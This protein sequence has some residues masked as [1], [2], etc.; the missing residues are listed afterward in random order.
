M[1]KISFYHIISW[2]LF[3]IIWLMV[4][5]TWSGRGLPPENELQY[6]TGNIKSVIVHSSPK[7]DIHHLQITDPKTN[8]SL[9]LACGNAVVPKI[10]M[11]NCTLAK[12]LPQKDITIGYYYQP[13]LFWIK[14]EIPQ[15]AVIKTNQSKDD[16][17]DNY[18]YSSTQTK[19]SVFNLITVI[20]AVFCSIICLFD[21]IFKRKSKVK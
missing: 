2:S 20:F 21:V 1:F 7:K 12:E 15:V 4:Y 8:Q 11:S 17:N 18:S 14:N 16:I 9:M 6:I 5:M 19:I 10:A 3:F 13:K